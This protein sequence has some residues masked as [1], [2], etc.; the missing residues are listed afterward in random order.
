MRWLFRGHQCSS[1]LGE[2]CAAS[3]AYKNHKVTSSS[4]HK[5]F[6]EGLDVV[7][8]GSLAKRGRWNPSFKERYFVLTS[9]GTLFYF[10]DSSA[11]STTST[12]LSQSS[13][14][15]CNGNSAS[16]RCCTSKALGFVPLGSEVVSTELCAGG[17]ADGYAQIEMSVKGPG[18]Q[19]TYILGAVSCVARDE[20]LNALR[21]V[22]T[23]RY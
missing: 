16:S 21:N 17:M 19:R 14:N 2:A 9:E 18:F 22:V 8:E 23:K 5:C 15:H 12:E 11:M 1:S 4:N 6:P 7:F 3:F 10:P 13:T 20:W